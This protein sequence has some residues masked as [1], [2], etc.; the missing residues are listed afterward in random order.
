MESEAGEV[1]VIASIIHT[2]G[3]RGSCKQQEAWAGAGVRH[4]GSRLEGFLSSAS[5]GR[6]PGVA[7]CEAGPKGGGLEWEAS[8]EDRD[9][10]LAGLNAALPNPGAPTCQEGAGREE[11]Y[12]RTQI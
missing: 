6:L 9:H 8:S 7:L 10:Q 12:A 4:R 11:I 1:G 5:P 2:C 3:R